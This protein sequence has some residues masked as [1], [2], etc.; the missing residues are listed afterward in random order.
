M[1]ALP[2]VSAVA[3]LM[4]EPTRAALLVS[5]LDGRARAAGELA[6]VARV[7][8]QAASNHLGRL[9]SFGLLSVRPLGR[10]RHYALAHREVAEALEALAALCP[11]RAA[12]H[13]PA[14]LRFARTCYDHLAGALGVAL[15]EAL[16]GRG[17]LLEEG[18]GYRTTPRGEAHLLS[19]GVQVQALR[20]GRRPFALSCLDWSERRPHL[21]GALGA[22]LLARLLALAFVV[23]LP[24]GRAARLTVAGRRALEAELGLRLPAA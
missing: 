20:Q 6:A 13:V 1:P 3:A 12:A 11:A 18:R 23:R 19:W 21:G 9:L 14:G 8:P 10:Q 17:L 2:D 24:E 5:L 4:A 22:A 15:R 16:L 7:S